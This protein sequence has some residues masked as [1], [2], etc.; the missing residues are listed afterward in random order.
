MLNVADARRLQQLVAG[1]AEAL[2][3]ELRALGRGA[4]KADRARSARVLEVYNMMFFICV[5]QAQIAGARSYIFAFFGK[6]MIF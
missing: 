3:E 2:G 4:S 5:S 6:L 1:A